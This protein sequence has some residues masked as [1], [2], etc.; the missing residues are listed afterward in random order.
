MDL[1]L[2]L[3]ALPIL[4]ALGWAGF[5]IGRAA[6]GQLQLMIKRAGG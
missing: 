4:L 1:R 5:N 6:L 2:A 3:V